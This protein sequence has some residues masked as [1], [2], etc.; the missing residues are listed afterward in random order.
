MVALARRAGERT[1]SAS[2]GRWFLWLALLASAAWL[3]LFGDKA[4]ARGEISLP[5]RATSPQVP[6][7]QPASEAMVALVPRKP[8]ASR[9]AQQVET[10]DPFASRRWNAPPPPPVAA[11]PA[12]PP[13]APPLPYAFL[14][15]K[16]EGGDW[17]V[18]LA[19]GDHNFVVSAGQVL[20]QHYRVET[21]APPL[22]TLTYLPLAQQQTLA[23]GEA[24]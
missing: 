8:L 5:T 20:E 2:R 7:A 17:E 3:A 15:K 21:I 1:V 23:I 14:G 11:A 10:R 6:Q 18:Y 24:R 4:P 22:L 19:R 9:D 12:A 13:A 16:Q